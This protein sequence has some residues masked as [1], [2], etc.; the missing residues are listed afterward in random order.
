MPKKYRIP[1][2][3]QMY[4]YVEVVADSLEDAIEEAESPETTLPE[5]SYVDSSFTV[6][7]DA[8]E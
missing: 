2:S 4:G 6:D 8:L 1:V 5:G 7:R 3:W